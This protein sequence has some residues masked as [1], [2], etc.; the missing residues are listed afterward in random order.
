MPI[1]VYSA[2]AFCLLLALAQPAAGAVMIQSKESE[3]GVQKTWIEGNRL[4][5]ETEDVRQYMLLDFDKRTMYLVNQDR[6]TVVDMSGLASAQGSG[7]AAKSESGFQVVK[8]GAGPVIAG[9]ASDHYVVRIGETTCMEAYTSTDAVT[10]LKL[11]G[12]IRG[13]ID[14]FPNAGTL[15][16]DDDPCR[17]AE[18]ALQYEE[19]GIPLRITKNGAENYNVIRIEQEASLPEH[20]FNIPNGYKTIDYSQ[21]VQEAMQHP[22]H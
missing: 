22:S 1:F 20:G 5:V 9:F 14:M 16:R 15:V 21:M 8:K 11:Q 19:I 2:T 10:N 6:E 7:D 3:A 17:F 12:F 4:R 13:M 18:T